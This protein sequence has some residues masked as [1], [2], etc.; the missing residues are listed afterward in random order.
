MAKFAKLFDV[1]PDGQVLFQVTRNEDGKASLKVTTEVDGSEVS[2]SYAFEDDSQASWD[3]AFTEL[4]QNATQEAADGFYSDM[5]SKFDVV[6]SGIILN[7]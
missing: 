3:Q 4:E 6:K 1:E 2:S 5:H 7:G